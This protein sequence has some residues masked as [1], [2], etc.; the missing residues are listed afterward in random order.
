MEP[1]GK[2]FVVHSVF[3]LFFIRIVRWIGEDKVEVGGTDVRKKGTP[4]KADS[5]YIN[6]QEKS[7]MPSHT[8]YSPGLPIA[9]F[10]RLI[11]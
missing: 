4:R 9:I 10:S 8:I 2:L 7:L 6:P 5:N 11:V 3:D 1:V